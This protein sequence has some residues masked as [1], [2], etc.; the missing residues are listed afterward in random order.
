MP[1]NIFCVLDSLFVNSTCH[2]QSNLHV[3][4][5]VKVSHFAYLWDFNRLIKSRKGRDA[6]N[7]ERIKERIL[8]DQVIIFFGRWR[9]QECIVT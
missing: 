8:R 7:Y 9:N 5:G 4:V 1:P 3:R 6:N 2:S